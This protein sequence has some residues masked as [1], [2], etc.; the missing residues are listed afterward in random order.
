MQLPDHHF[1][2]H[3]MCSQPNSPSVLNYFLNSSD[4][5]ADASSKEESDGRSRRYSEGPT[6]GINA[7]GR[8]HEPFFLLSKC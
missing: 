4:G 8:S 7:S 2:T 5:E 6:K 1:P 3:V